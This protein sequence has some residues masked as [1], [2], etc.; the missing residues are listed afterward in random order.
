V[1]GPATRNQITALFEKR[2][3]VGL[4]GAATPFVFIWDEDVV[5]CIVQGVH[6][7]STGVYNLAG[8]GVMTLREIAA[9]L[10]RRY[11]AVSPRLMRAALAGLRRAGLT[12]YGPEQVAF[13]QY[14]PV[15][16][17]DRLKQTFGYRPR[18]TTREAFEA[19]ATS[20][21]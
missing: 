15:L 3:V 1:L 13:L 6:G 7:E 17:N 4:R 5:A 18:R 2:V 20:R 11:V 10:G 14:R 16:S 19:Y 21:A 8:D 12:Q 9:R